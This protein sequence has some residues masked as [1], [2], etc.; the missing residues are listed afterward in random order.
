MIAELLTAESAC[1][2]SLLLCWQQRCHHR[3]PSPAC[4]PS[5]AVVDQQCI[6]LLGRCSTCMLHAFSAKYQIINFISFFGMASYACYAGV[7]CMGPHCFVAHIRITAVEAS[8]QHLGCLACLPADSLRCLHSL[9]GFHLIL[10]AP[11]FACLLPQCLLPQ[12]RSP[13][14]APVQCTV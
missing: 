5:R 4:K 3:C 6:Q 8:P 1:V 11:P 2:Q 14:H 7:Q 10:L 13:V 12:C 9:H